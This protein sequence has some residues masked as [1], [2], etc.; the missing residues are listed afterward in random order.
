MGALFGPAGNAQSFS[1]MGYKRQDQIPDYLSVFGLTA[2]EYQ[3]GRG[4]R[5]NAENAR[6][7]KE[8]AEE[9]QIRVSL[10][11]PYIELFRRRKIVGF[12]CRLRCLCKP[13]TAYASRKK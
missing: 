5:V 12:S 10:H 6:K 1:E 3:C 4:V 7:F 13:Q 9:K 2:Y 8:N 11:T